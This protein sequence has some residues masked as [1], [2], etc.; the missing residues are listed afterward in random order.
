[1]YCWDNGDKMIVEC[2]RHVMLKCPAYNKDRVIFG[3]ELTQETTDALRVSPRAEDKVDIIFKATSSQDWQATSQF[4]S[5]VRQRR[6]ALRKLYA[7]RQ[8]ELSVVG[9]DACKRDAQQAGSKLWVCRH[10]LF[11]H[12]SRTL[13]C[14][15]ME[16]RSCTARARDWHGARK[17]PQISKAHRSI[18]TV[19]F[20]AENVTASWNITVS[21]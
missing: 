4:L 19:P 14:Q 2:E 12:T 16:N 3:R 7:S 8:K 21:K 13:P 10:G 9:Y 17:M 15:C 5:R 1:M 18:I 20:N 11:F 6:R